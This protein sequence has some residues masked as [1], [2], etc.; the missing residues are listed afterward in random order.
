MSAPEAPTARGLDN[1]F[2][3]VALRP[4]HLIGSKMQTDIDLTELEQRI[5]AQFGLNRGILLCVGLAC[6]LLGSLAVALPLS[7]FGSFV[8]L[9]GVLLLASAGL[10]ACQLLLGRRSASARERGWPLIFLQVAIDAAMG[11]VLLQ[12]WK[13]S[14]RLA[15]V[16]LGLLF[17]LEGLILGY[18]ALRA[19]TLRSRNAVLV[20]AMLTLG[21]GVVIVLS[22]VPDPLRWAGLFVGLKLILFG[23]TLCW[24]ALRALRSERE[25][26][27]EATSP[28]PIPGELYAVYFGTAFHLGV[29]IGDGE[30]VHYLNDNHVYRVTWPQFLAGRGPQHWTYPDLEPEPLEKIVGTALSEV[31]KTYPYHLL[32]CN[33]EH[34]AIFCRSAGKTRFSKYAQVS[35]G[36]ESVKAYPLLGLVAE[37]N[38]RAVEWLAFHFG[39]PAGKRLSLA[40]RRTGAAV[41]RWLVSPERQAAPE[42]GR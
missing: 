33:C 20:T 12:E 5:E 8:K 17:V 2:P 26:L 30:V 23:G 3:P 22:L 29:Y 4:P 24:V 25:L 21:I 11:V 38:T 32:T 16:A 9:V 27:Y 18:M 41:T 28:E 42:A 40:I 39:G 31:G 7:V 15:S 6:V 37:L 19:P 14:A 1:L 13:G 35:A 36:I 10:K 34:F